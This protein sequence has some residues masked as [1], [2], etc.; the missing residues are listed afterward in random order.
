MLMIIITLYRHKPKVLL[1]CKMLRRTFLKCEVA[2]Q[3][4]LIEYILQEVRNHYRKMMCRAKRQAKL[5]TYREVI[6]LIVIVNT[7]AISQTCH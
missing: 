5:T 7:T 1:H 2:R 6:N 4:R 3:K